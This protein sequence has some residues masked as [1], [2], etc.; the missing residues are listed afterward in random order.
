MREE[1]DIDILLAQPESNFLVTRLSVCSVFPFL[2]DKDYTQHRQHGQR[3]CPC[4][5]W[6]FLSDAAAVLELGPAEPFSIA[7]SPL[8]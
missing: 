5:I 1:S 8:G 3:D 2:M 6:H 4:S 7:L